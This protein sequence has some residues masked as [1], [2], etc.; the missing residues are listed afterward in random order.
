MAEFL[1]TVFKRRLTSEGTIQISL[2]AL[3]Y[4]F[5]CRCIK[6]QLYLGFLFHLY[7]GRCR[8]PAYSTP[9]LPVSAL[10]RLPFLV[11]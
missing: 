3:A 5:T 6:D 8:A 9:V 2:F 4:C 11:C 7:F 10:A 1:D